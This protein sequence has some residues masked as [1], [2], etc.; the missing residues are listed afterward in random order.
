MTEQLP[1]AVD[2]R[3]FFCSPARLLFANGARHEVSALCAAQ[4]W[5]HALIVTDRYFTHHSPLIRQLVDG[6]AR[7]GIVAEICDDGV[8]DPSV[9]LCDQVSARLV[10]SG[11][12]GEIDHLIAVGGGSNIDLAKALSL[13]LKFARPCAAFVGRAAL[14][15]RPLPLVAMP[16]TAGAGSELTPGAIL[17]DRRNATKVAVMSNDLRP[18]IAVIDPEL[19]LSCPRRV[20]ADAGIDALTHAVESYL[21]MDAT[22]FDRR[23]Q[24]DPP[25]SGRNRM[26]R[27]W[28]TQAIQLCFEHLPVCL[29][30]PDDLRARTGMAYGSLYAAMSYASAGL[31]AVHA[32]A[33]GLAGLTGESHGRTNGVLLPYVM[34]A[35]RAE[36]EPELAQIARLAGASDAQAPELAQLAPHL[37]REL[38]ALAGIPVTL[39][40]FGLEAALLPQLAE[41]GL[42]VSRLTQAFPRADTRPAYT[43]IVAQAFNGSLSWGV[44]P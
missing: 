38:V 39:R 32:L 44:R 25:Y 5:R 6:L 36:R 2:E 15:G 22:A 29:D 21:T 1:I 43:A 11:K 33:Y 35:L 12:A 14:P 28:A 40:S 37:I 10:A 27:L 41:A 30:A 23:G 26:T 17:V 34:D 13:T 31:H 8:P 9:E 7:H 24:P 19:T 16:T 20:T 18:L 42:A 3:I 4:G